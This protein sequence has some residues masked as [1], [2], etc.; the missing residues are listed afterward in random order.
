ME[1][2]WLATGM[3]Y[4]GVYSWGIIQGN[5]CAA[6]RTPPGEWPAWTVDSRPLIRGV[7][8]D[9]AQGVS[10]ATISRRFHS[11]I[12]ELIADVCRLLRASSGL[13]QVALTGGVFMNA[14]L[15]SETESLLSADG[16]EVYLHRRVPAN[17]GGLSLGQLA[18]AAHVLASQKLAEE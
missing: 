2:E 12:V 17:D 7:A 3:P 6:P 4:Q 15:C 11:T 10:A 13:S 9:V 1:L 16:F 8:T 14:L 18:V 5:A